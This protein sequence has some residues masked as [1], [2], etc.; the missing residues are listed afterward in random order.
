MPFTGWTK[1]TWPL[2]CFFR[3]RMCQ[4]SRRGREEEEEEEEARAVWR[5]WPNSRGQGGPV[6][7]AMDGDDRHRVRA[8]VGYVS[9]AVW[10]ITDQQRVCA[11]SCS[12]LLC[13]QEDDLWKKYGK[14]S[15]WI[16]KATVHPCKYKYIQ[17]DNQLVVL[18]QLLRFAKVNLKKRKSKDDKETSSGKVVFVGWMATKFSVSSR[19]RLGFV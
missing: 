9:G 4:R 1:V 6:H 3:G 7:Y 15:K 8:R 2:P 16:W 10:G 5:R 12:L 13:R 11:H 17:N 14:A 19:E 18:V